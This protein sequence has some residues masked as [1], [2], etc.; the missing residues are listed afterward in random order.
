FRDHHQDLQARGAD[1]YGLSTQGSDYQREV[2]ERL[3]LPFEI[4]SDEQLL[5]KQHLALPT[6]TVESRELYRRITLVV[7]EG[8]IEQV[9]YPVFPPNESAEVVLRWL[10]AN[11]S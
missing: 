5:L 3:H 9:F 4:L 7:K 8:R 6:F 2:S 10:A 1:V 11:S